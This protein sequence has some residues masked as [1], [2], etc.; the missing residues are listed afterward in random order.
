MKFASTRV[1]SLTTFAS[2]CVGCSSQSA[3]SCMQPFPF[4]GPGESEIL[5]LAAATGNRVPVAG[6]PEG[7][8][9]NP[10]DPVTAWEFVVQRAPSI[11]RWSSE[12][13]PLGSPFIDPRILVQSDTFLAVPWAHDEACVWMAWNE[14][15]WIPAGREAVFRISKT[16]FSYGRHVIDLLGWY[17][18][19]PYGDSLQVKSLTEAPVA[20][21][22]WLGPQELLSLY[23]HLPPQAHERSRTEQLQEIENQYRIGPTAWVD[24][25]PGLEMVQ[26]ARAWA[27]S[28]ATH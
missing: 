12:T 13:V 2:V 15:E 25:F 27:D 9:S 8:L 16:R 1:L 20:I 7:L 11:V 14:E 23:W 26:R 24:R 4:F 3:V 22:E 18:P 6:G 10:A 28:A 19:Y 17:G 5:V 21:E